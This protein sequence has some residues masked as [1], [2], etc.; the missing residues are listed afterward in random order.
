MDSNF[1]FCYY[2]VVFY[3]NF[4]KISKINFRLSIFKLLLSLYFILLAI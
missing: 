2:N 4:M 3:F 1:W